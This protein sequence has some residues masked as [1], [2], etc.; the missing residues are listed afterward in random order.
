MWKDVRLRMAE[1]LR[2]I[3]E[4]RAALLPTVLAVLAANFIGDIA[5][6]VTAL[7]EGS[8]AFTAEGVTLQ[9]AARALGWAAGGAI[10]SKK[11]LAQMPN[12]VPVLTG[13][14][15]WFRL[16]GPISDLTALVVGRTPPE[17]T[18]F[19][20]QL[21]AWLIFIPFAL[22]FIYFYVP[23]ISHSFFNCSLFTFSLSLF[24]FFFP[25]FLYAG[26]IFLCS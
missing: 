17:Y 13:I 26:L 3:N 24:I 1:A 4:H 16:Y 22:L 7:R 14:V 25:H 6:A 23:I 5:A 12:I 9:G 8:S 18:I 20:W 10:Q 15:L 2:Y 19:V 11:W 21:L